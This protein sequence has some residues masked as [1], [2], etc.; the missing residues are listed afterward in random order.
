MSFSKNNALPTDNVQPGQWLGMLGGGQ[1]GRMFCQA[2]Q[3][4][5]YRVAVLDPDPDSPAGTI[6]NEHI[7]CDYQDTVGL[8][9]LAR[10]CAAVST[11]FEN[12]PSESLLHL[13]KHCVVRPSANAVAITQNRLVEKS[14][15]QKAGVPVAPHTRINS[16]HDA[17]QAPETLFPGILKSARFGYDGKGQVRV[18]SRQELIDAFNQLGEVECI[19]EALIPLEYEISVVLGRDHTG[20]VKCYPAVLNEHRDGI[21]AVSVSGSFEPGSA[22]QQQA[23]D[24]ASAIAAELDY[25]GVLCVEF[26]VTANG[27]L[28]ANEMAPRPH[29]SGHYTI[30]A[31]I[32]SQFEQQVRILAGMP[33]GSTDDTQRSVMINVLGDVWFKN[34]TIAKEPE[35]HKVLNVPGAHLHLYG[36]TSVKKGRK[37]GHIT[38]TAD[39][40]KQAMD[41]A[42]TVGS[43]IGISL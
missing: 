28:M 10:Q 33:L 27:T 14:F 13:A 36:K 15:F 41:N 37:M 29:N 43:I 31:S 25:V 19:L 6:A 38:I 2:A 7:H 40:A 24:M 34:S 1:L 11:E 42:R 5:G 22:I 17:Q 9:R 3:S 39:T 18:S 23:Q 20:D 12:I 30:D 26:F 21:L 16:L 8:Q 4:M 35:W 32:C